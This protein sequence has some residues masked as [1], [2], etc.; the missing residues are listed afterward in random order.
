[1]KIRPGTLPR[2]HTTWFAMWLWWRKA[3]VLSWQSGRSYFAE[4][5]HSI[6]RMALRGALLQRVKQKSSS[7]SSPPACVW[8]TSR[9]PEELSR[10]LAHPSGPSGD[11]A[12]SAWRCC[13]SPSQSAQCSKSLQPDSAIHTHVY[14]YYIFMTFSLFPP[15]PSAHR[16]FKLMESCYKSESTSSSSN[17]SPPHTHTQNQVWTRVTNPDGGGGAGESDKGASCFVP[18]S[19]AG[20]VE[21]VV[22]A[23]DEACTLPRV[24]MTHL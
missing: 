17:A 20:G 24:G 11:P 18:H 21:Q 12:Q 1:M 19:W 23:P 4:Q 13:H 3:L 10:G 6:L 16:A 22:D 2:L 15:P 7:F 5:L 8:A 9:L 14:R